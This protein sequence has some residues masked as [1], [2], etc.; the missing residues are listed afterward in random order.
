MLIDE[1]PSPTFA[2][3]ENGNVTVFIPEMMGEPSNPTVSWADETTLLF[4][5]SP[6]GACHLTY[7]TDE[8]MSRLGK[9]EKCLVIELD[10]E[11]VVDLYDQVSPDLESAFKK[12][13]EA[14]VENA[15][16]VQKGL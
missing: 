16:F 9:V 10:M 13:Y 7:V 8:S 4:R 11:K 14:K 15:S 1:I 6:E 2:L 5:R 3:N 12:V